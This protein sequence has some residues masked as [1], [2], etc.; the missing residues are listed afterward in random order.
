MTLQIEKHFLYI[1]Q[2]EEIYSKLSEQELTY[3]Q[4][5]VEVRGT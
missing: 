1:L 4:K 3:A 5:Y 2:N